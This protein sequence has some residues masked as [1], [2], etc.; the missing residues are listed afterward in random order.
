[1]NIPNYLWGESIRHATYLINRVATRSL[2]AQT[3]Y[4]VFKGKKPSI[5]HLRVFGCIGYAKFKAP[6]LRKLVDRSRTLVHLGTEPGSKTYRM[7]DPTSRKIVVS[8][9]V[10]FD[11]HKTWKWNNRSEEDEEP[12][13]FKITFGV[14]GNQGICDEDSNNETE[15]RNNE[16]EEQDGVE[17][18]DVTNAPSEKKDAP[19][20]RS[21]HEKFN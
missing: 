18:V 19:P 9:D 1:M 5:K 6:H 3:P 17:E 11:E 20:R 13:R 21:K 14:F 12:W 16:L 10:V 2:N 7:L 4:E 15:D 8:R